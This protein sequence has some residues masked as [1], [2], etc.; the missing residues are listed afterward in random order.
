[1]LLFTGCS[2]PEAVFPV[3]PRIEFV[4]MKPRAISSKDTLCFIQNQCFSITF[5]FE[6]G[7]GD[8]G[9]NNFSG[10]PNI[11]ITDNRPNLPYNNP[12]IY[13]NG[14]LN[15][16]LPRS[17]TPETRNQSIQGT[18][19]IAMPYIPIINF[20]DEPDT[21]TFSI[22]I[23]DRSGNKSNTITTPPLVIYP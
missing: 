4:E 18:I 14:K 15:F 2:T 13:Y 11:F 16:R 12:P 22:Y 20:F 1:M 6:D 17:L 5:R 10:P 19:T 8:L 23:V 21:T 7:D 9:T 3:I